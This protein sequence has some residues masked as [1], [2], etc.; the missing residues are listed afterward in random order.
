MVQLNNCY[1]LVDWDMGGRAVTLERRRRSPPLLLLLLAA[2]FDAVP[3]ATPLP[4]TGLLGTPK[5]SGIAGSAG[6][7][8]VV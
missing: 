6:A 5:R 4:P 7:A 3:A 8:A 2:L 1:R